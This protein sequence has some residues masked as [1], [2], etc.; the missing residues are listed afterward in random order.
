MYNLSHFRIELVVYSLII[1]V[2]VFCQEFYIYLFLK[3][4][5]FFMEMLFYWELQYNIIYDFR[6]FLTLNSRIHKFV[7]YESTSTP[8][9]P[10]IFK[11]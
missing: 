1:R 10:K 8:A 11:I 7:I 5:V 2:P 3:A 6:Y 9:S 4:I